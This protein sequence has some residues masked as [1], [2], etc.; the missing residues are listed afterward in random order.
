[1]DPAS[2][3][4]NGPGWRFP[5]PRGDGPSP[6]GP[7]DARRWVSPPTRG[8]THAIKLSALS[9]C[10]FP[11]HAGMDPATRQTAQLY[12]WF[13]RPRGDGP[14]LELHRIRVEEVSPPTRGW[15]RVVREPLQITGGFPAHAGMD[16]CRACYS[17]ITTRFPR[18]RGDGPQSRRRR[19][20]LLR[21]S[22]PTRGWTDIAG[23]RSEV[24]A[25]FPA[26]A[27]MDP[28]SDGPARGTSRFPRPRGDGPRK[29]KAS[30]RGVLVS[31]PTRGW[32]PAVTGD[33]LRAPG[34]PAH[35]GMDLLSLTSGAG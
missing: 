25:G 16:P 5:R 26:H 32:T 35:A 27:G 15:T 30:V 6:R 28:R 33:R 10:G 12:R 20:C 3:S 18:P 7:E 11:A 29:R 31:P 14:G 24:T 17:P 34:F 19:R 21:V 13:P 4:R 1:M 8:W 2:H 22:P 9:C 23:L